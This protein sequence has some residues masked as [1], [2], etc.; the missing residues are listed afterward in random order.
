M[1]DVFGK[2]VSKLKWSACRELVQ[3][4]EGAVKDKLNDL[5]GLPIEGTSAPFPGTTTVHFGA[6]EAKSALFFPTKLGL[7]DIKGHKL[8][9]SGVSA[10]GYSGRW[11]VNLKI[12]QIITKGQYEIISTVTDE[13]LFRFKITEQMLRTPEVKEAFDFDPKMFRPPSAPRARL[14]RAIP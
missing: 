2:P 11:V 10:G 7:R 4:P 8:D 12:D 1:F 6:I 5:L 14:P 9:C 3:F 13:A